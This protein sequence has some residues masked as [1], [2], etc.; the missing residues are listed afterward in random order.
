MIRILLLCIV[1]HFLSACGVHTSSS[2]KTDKAYYQRQV[3]PAGGYHALY[4]HFSL[5]DEAEAVTQ[6]KIN[7]VE[8]PFEVTNNSGNGIEVYLLEQDEKAYEGQPE[9]KK[10][11]PELF[12]A[13]EYRAVISLKNQELT[14]PDIPKLNNQSL[15]Q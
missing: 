11:Y 1:M 13:T 6:V 8:V 4:F 12:K 3:I 5:E 9:P 7:D 2:Q 14:Y 10:N 15:P